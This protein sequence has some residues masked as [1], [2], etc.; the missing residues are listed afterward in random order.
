MSWAM[1]GNIMK[2]KWFL[3]VDK[4][5]T[6]LT[7][8]LC[9]DLAKARFDPNIAQNLLFASF[10]CVWYGEHE[11]SLRRARGNFPIWENTRSDTFLF[12]VIHMGKTKI[13][14]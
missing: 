7:H 4:G 14:G 11:N 13:S 8:S 12:A 1:L 9:R 10:V 3:F 5:A 6:R 2:R